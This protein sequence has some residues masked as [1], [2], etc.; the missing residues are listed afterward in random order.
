M[1]VFL[2]PGH[3]PGLDNGA[4]NREHGTKEAEYAYEIGVMVEKYLNAAGV[5]TDFLQSNSINGEDEDYNNPS[6]VRTA[7][8]S[9][10]DLFISL[11]CNAFN[12]EARGTETLVYE[13]YGESAYLADAIQTQLVD[14]LTQVDP[15]WIDRGLKERSNLGVLKYTNM[16]AVLVEI[17]FIDNES[18]HEVLINHK[19]D[20]ARAIA[21]GV[22]DYMQ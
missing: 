12:C 3:K 10:A 6:I 22:T 18:D 5:E 2:N 9:G 8:A 13:M 11:H 4:W 19:D 20:I 15:N 14:I 21:R 17:G 16:P 1:K 7:N